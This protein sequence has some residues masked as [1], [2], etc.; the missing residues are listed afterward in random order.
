MVWD[1]MA[2][3]GAFT[4]RMLNF[5]EAHLRRQVDHRDPDL[6]VFMFGGNDLQLGKRHLEEYATNYATVLRNFRGE[7][8]RPCLVIA[9]VDHGD[10]EGERIVSRKMVPL[11][12]DTQR[13]VAAEVGCAFFDTFEAMGGNGSASRW[14][15]SN[16]PL[17]A[18]DLAHL[19]RHGQQV[20]GHWV[21][22]ALMAEYV[23]Y[24]RRG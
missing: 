3:I 12:V 10:R 9:P 5:D 24:R 7:A 19:N 2:Q 16:P 8:Q 14:R 4:S 6:L 20:V 15:H 23:K 22:L 1:G 13:E 11:L 21:Y 17:I 18:G